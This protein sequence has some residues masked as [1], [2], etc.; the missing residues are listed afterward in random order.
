MPKYAHH[1]FVC[2]N[3]RDPQHPR[4]SCD[5]KNT[6]KLTDALKS[7]VKD[8]KSKLQGPIRINKAGCLDQCEHGPVI[9]IYPQ[10]IWYGNVTPNDAVRIVNETLVEGRIL[11][12][13]LISDSCLN[14]ASCPHKKSS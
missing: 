10:E 11:E 8:Q 6:G 1:L 14:S 3:S 2:G 13:L 9:V 5:P 4:G 12:D 7:A